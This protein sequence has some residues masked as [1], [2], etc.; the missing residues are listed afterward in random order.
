MNWTLGD[1]IRA[2][3]MASTSAAAFD[4]R[5]RMR[6]RGEHRGPPARSAGQL[7]HIP[8][9]REALGHSPQP[10]QVLALCIRPVVLGRTGP[11]VGELL[12]QEGVVIAAH[13]P[14][15]YVLPPLYYPP[16]TA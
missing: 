10:L 4:S 6:P 15:P 14:R 7:Q 5:D 13:S 1:A 2:R 9:N 16:K 8:G 11:V 3:A 12:R